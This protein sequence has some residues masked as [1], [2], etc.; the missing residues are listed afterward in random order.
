MR[1]IAKLLVTD[2]QLKSVQAE[3][4]LKGPAPLNKYNVCFQ[5]LNISLNSLVISAD[6]KRRYVFAI[7]LHLQALTKGCSNFRTKELDGKRYHHQ[8]QLGGT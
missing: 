8:F 4:P 3:K 6:S 1:G 7:P 2:A 5:L